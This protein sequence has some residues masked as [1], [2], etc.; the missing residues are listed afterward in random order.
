MYAMTCSVV[1]ILS[2]VREEWIGL[3]STS[4]LHFIFACW[5]QLANYL[6]S[7]NTVIE[8]RY[9]IGKQTWP[10][11]H[12]NTRRSECDVDCGQSTGHHLLPSRLR[13]R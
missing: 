12:S 4:D 3:A 6:V 11:G 9:I 13:K 1:P 2:D 8:T 7:G 5:T 10:H